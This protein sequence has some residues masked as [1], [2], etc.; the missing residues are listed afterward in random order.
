MAQARYIQH[1][2]GEPSKFMHLFLCIFIA[3]KQKKSVMEHFVQNR[4]SVVN[5]IFAAWKDTLRTLGQYLSLS[6]NI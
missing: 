2:F 4:I 6:V 5:E 3:I 1:I